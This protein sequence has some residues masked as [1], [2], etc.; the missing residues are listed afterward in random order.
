MYCCADIQIC[1]TSLS[2]CLCH[3]LQISLDFFCLDEPLLYGIEVG[4]CTFLEHSKLFC[5]LTLT[6]DLL[7]HI[8]RYFML[9]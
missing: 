6:L 4:T 7:Y 8:Y 2:E 9:M 5:H 1:D 3:M